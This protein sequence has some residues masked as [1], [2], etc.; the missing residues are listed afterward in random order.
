VDP[1][2]AW[3]KSLES[4]DSSI[5]DAVLTLWPADSKD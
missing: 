2:M 3:I 5:Y 1:M 4:K